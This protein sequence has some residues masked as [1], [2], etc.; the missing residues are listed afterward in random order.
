MH[1]GPEWMR[2]K[3]QPASKTL[4]SPSP[5]PGSAGLSSGASILG[6]S[7]SQNSLLHPEKRD[8]AHP[9]RYT[10]EDMLKIYR[11]HSG[12]VSLGPDVE[13]WEGVVREA[14]GDPIGLKDLDEAEK[15]VLVSCCNLSRLF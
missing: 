9:Y 11:E 2:A 7:H 4:T 13:R 3:P 1:F 8:D 6:T 5:P 12:Q 15:K 14:A 10:K